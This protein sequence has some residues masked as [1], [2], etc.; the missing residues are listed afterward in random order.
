MSREKIYSIKSQINEHIPEL[1]DKL[2]LDYK[3]IDNRIVMPCPVHGGDNPEACCIFLTGTKQVGNWCCWTHACE[4]EYGSD[5]LGFIRGFKKI[6]FYESV[7]YAL[8]LLNV[9]I[10]SIKEVFIAHTIHKMNQITEEFLKERTPVQSNIKREDV[11]KNLEIPSKYFLSRGFKQSTLELFDVGDCNN[12][13]KE[14]NGRAVVP[15]YDENYNYVGCVG[16]DIYD[17][18]DRKWKNSKGLKKN[19]LYGYNISQKDIE[20]TKTIILVEGQGDVWKLYEN[21]IRNAVGIFGVDISD[22]Q[23]FFL[24]S[25]CLENMVILTDMDDPG[26]KAVQSIKNKCGRRFNYYVPTFEEKDVGSMTDKQIETV[27]KPQIKGLF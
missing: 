3:I 13:T 15:I 26:R 1:I 7:D 6:N 12:P 2:G 20:R 8:H 16:R 23:L 5:M 21:N 17:T 14:M 10:D 9:D 22:D 11:I 18:D 4:K 25:L 24:D 27:L 19:I